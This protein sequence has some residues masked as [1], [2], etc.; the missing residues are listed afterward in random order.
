MNKHAI[1]IGINDYQF[2]GKLNFA[3]QD[4]EA[5]AT[6][7][8][9]NY[10]FSENEIT[11]M[12]GMANRLRPTDK[13]A[14]EDML[15]PECLGEN[16]DLLI[17]G[18]WGHGIWS[19]GNRYLCPMNQRED[20]LQDLGLSLETIKTRLGKIGAKNIC[21]ILDCCQSITLGR[22]GV[23]ESVSEQEINAMPL[24]ARDIGLKVKEV[25]GCDTPP[26]VAILNACSEGQRAYE[27]EQKQHGIFT[28]HLLDVLNEPVPSVSHLFNAIKP[29]IEK[30]ARQNNVKQ[31]PYYF[32]EGGT[33]IILP[34]SERLALKP[35][36]ELEIPPVL[37]CKTSPFTEE[38]DC[39]EPFLQAKPRP[40]HDAMH[41]DL[42]DIFAI[43]GKFVLGGNLFFFGGIFPGFFGGMALGAL[44]GGTLG[45][46]I[47]AF[48]GF[49][50]IGLLCGAFGYVFGAFLGR[51]TGACLHRISSGFRK[52][53]NVLFQY[54]KKL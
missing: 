46:I 38:N 30:T 16:L 7:L 54:E 48:I 50:L 3:R 53:I 20:R 25:S 35:Q 37:P 5:V 40:W 4:A 39:L 6:A 41:C 8:K 9:Q 28:A 29:R 47:G 1:L 27:W 36:P 44:L 33:D 34:A 52:A 11:L 15:C 24:L 21:L 12:T 23:S 43:I 31:S 10:G 49:I 32:C 22:G 2:L 14:I 17:F 51:F 42:A 13:Y 26:T 18:F 19:A 45:G